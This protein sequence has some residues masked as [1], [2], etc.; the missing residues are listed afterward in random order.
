[1][2]MIE[3]LTLT[4]YILIISY[5]KLITDEHHHVKFFIHFSHLRRTDAERRCH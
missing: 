3:D 1:M 4:K 5:V 2:S